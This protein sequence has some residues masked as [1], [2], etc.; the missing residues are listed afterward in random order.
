MA[1]SLKDVAPSFLF[2]LTQPEILKI[3]AMRSMG[4][5]EAII[6]RSDAIIYSLFCIKIVLKHTVELPFTPPVF[7]CLSST[8]QILFNQNTIKYNVYNF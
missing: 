4:L 3:T 2:G 8:I 5:F 7:I 1:K 6:L